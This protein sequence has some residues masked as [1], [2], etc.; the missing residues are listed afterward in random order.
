MKHMRDHTLHHFM[1]LQFK[2]ITT[3]IWVPWEY[4]TNNNK[5][6]YFRNKKNYERRS[7]NGKEKNHY[8]HLEIRFS[9]HRHKKQTHLDAMKTKLCAYSQSIKQLKWNIQI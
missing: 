1:L 4:E 7:N 2:C 3:N 6:G 5:M 9:K 8:S